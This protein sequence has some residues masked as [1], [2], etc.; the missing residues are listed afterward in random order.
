MKKYYLTLL[1]FFSLL[2]LTFSKPNKEKFLSINEENSQSDLINLRNLDD[3]EDEDDIEDPDEEGNGK[4]NGTTGQRAYHKSSGGLSGGGIA[5][6]VICVVFVVV[7]VI[8]LLVIF[9]TG[10]IVGFSSAAVAIGSTQGALMGTNTLSGAANSMVPG[11]GNFGAGGPQGDGAYGH[12]YGG[13]GPHRPHGPHGPP[14]GP[15]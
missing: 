14:H 4:G 12:N 10:A 13:H 2:I 7:A 11:S 6:I 9:Q 5:A 1:C 3:D 15:H 8:A